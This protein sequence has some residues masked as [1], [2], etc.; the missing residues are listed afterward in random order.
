MYDFIL[1]NLKGE[2]LTF[3]RIGGDFTIEEIQGLSPASATINTSAAAYL[4][5][6]L[7]N[8]SKVDMRTL[9]IAF[10]I[11]KN[12]A[13][14]RIKIYNVLKPKQAVRAYYKSATRDVYID[15]YV[16]SVEITHFNMKQICTV[17]I[18]C[19]LPFWQDAQQQSSAL[20]AVQGMFHF[21]FA[22]LATPELV[23]SYI[24]PYTSVEVAN[25]GDVQ[26]GIIIELYASAAVSNPK[27]FDYLTG[28]FIELNFNMQPADLITIDTRVGNK[29]ITLLRDAVESNIFNSWVQGSKWLQLDFGGSVYAYEVG[30]GEASDLTVTIKHLNLYEGV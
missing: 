13:A 26:T 17:S 19:P 27:I 6:A 3:N 28:D 4:D 25:D 1:E 21:P 11:E 5:G 23:F 10:A 18:L 15:G 7:F 8:S 16:Q 30:S 9:Q 24:D 2:R 12:A 20:S 29:T 14:N 22:S